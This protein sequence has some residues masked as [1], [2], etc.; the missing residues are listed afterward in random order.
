MRPVRR[1]ESGVGRRNRMRLEFSGVDL[2]TLVH[3]PRKTGTSGGPGEGEKETIGMDQAN[4]LA[5]KA[6]G[7]R[8]VGL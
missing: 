8:E 1:M 2:D 4:Q 7:G 5:E 3:R 6:G